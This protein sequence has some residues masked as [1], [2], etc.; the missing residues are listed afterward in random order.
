MNF[1]GLFD[2]FG[3]LAFLLNSDILCD[4]FCKPLIA[5]AMLP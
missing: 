5:K 1:E 3:H 2:V 4:G